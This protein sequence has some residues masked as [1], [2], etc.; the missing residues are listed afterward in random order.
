MPSFQNQTVRSISQSP[1][2]LL[3]GLKVEGSPRDDPPRP[4]VLPPA[5]ANHHSTM[6]VPAAQMQPTGSGTIPVFG[7]IIA[8]IGDISVQLVFNK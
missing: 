2:S 8:H 5:C 7:C 6:V 1:G 3:A 4:A